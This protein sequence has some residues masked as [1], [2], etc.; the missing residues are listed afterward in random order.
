MD[1]TESADSDGDGVGDN[2]DPFPNVR[3]DRDNDGVVDVADAFPDDPTETQR[4]RRRQRGQQRGRLP[5]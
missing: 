4:Q 1:G 2:A 5:L 3:N